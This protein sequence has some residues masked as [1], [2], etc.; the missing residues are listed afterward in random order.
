MQLTL[1][2]ARFRNVLTS[3]NFADFNQFQLLFLI[4]DDTKYQGYSDIL[5]RF[6]S[7]I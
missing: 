5:W 6:L 3:Y 1:Q 2:N 4:F 7:C